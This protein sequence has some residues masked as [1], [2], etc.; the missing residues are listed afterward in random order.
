MSSP[1]YP[2][3]LAAWS[4][5]RNI[6]T[7][8]MRSWENRA[9]TSV[10]DEPF[11]GHYLQHTGKNHPNTAEIIAAMECD[12]DRVVQQLIG[13][14]PNNSNIFYQKHMAHHLLPHMS[15]AWFDQVT[16]VFLIRDPA[17]MLRSLDAKLDDITVED[18]GLPQQ[19]EIFEYVTKEQGGKPLV[20]DARDV[21]M[22]PRKVLSGLCAHL[23]I[24]FD[25]G[26]LSWP[27]GRRD[28]DGVWAP[29]WY[30]SVEASTGFIP[31]APKPG[32]LPP[33]LAD[34]Y[35]TCKL[36]YEQLYAHRIA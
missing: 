2:L 14:V 19:V 4:G 15:R 36:Y 24:P 16:H 8:M 35:V 32:D 20:L 12:P 3:R 33:H 26:M 9:D 25:E 27:A 5:P 21:L 30:A 7:A 1:S 34:L 6:S 29:Y 31:Y 11:Y 17:E 10:C 13:P 23:E 18:T 22:N 28:S